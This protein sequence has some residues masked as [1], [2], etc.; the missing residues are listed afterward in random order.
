M[1]YLPKSQQKKQFSYSGKKAANKTFRNKMLLGEIMCSVSRSMYVKPSE[2]SLFIQ[3]K[4]R[5]ILA[6][7]A[8][9]L[10]IKL[11]KAKCEPTCTFDLQ[12]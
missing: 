7:L 10:Q 12:M 6:S 2:K 4:L 1:R 8:L 11:W 5:A 3:E 9:R